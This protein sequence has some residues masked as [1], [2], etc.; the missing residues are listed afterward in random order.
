M[1]GKKEER[2]KK[3]L[4]FIRKISGVKHFYDS[5][6][7]S[8]VTLN[9]YSLHSIENVM[10]MSHRSPHVISTYWT[11]VKHS[12]DDG[13]ILS[14]GLSHSPDNID[15]LRGKEELVRVEKSSYR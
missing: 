7:T 2:E 5:S 11:R 14:M 13:A 4:L 3:L 1:V 8:L 10:M 12:L 9:Y 15:N 6:L